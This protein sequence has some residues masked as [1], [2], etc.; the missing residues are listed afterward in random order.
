MP[1]PI[2]H[3]AAGVL[4]FRIFRRYLGSAGRARSACLVAVF[5]AFSLAPDLDSVA[6]VLFGDFGKYHNNMTHSM[7]FGLVVATVFALFAAPFQRGRTAVWFLAALLCC[8]LH[9]LMDYF[10][11]GRGVML[12]WPLTEIRYQPPVKL[13]YGVHWSDGWVSMRHLKTAVTEGAII[14]GVWMLLAA[15]EERR[16]HIQAAGNHENPRESASHGQHNGQR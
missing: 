5:A 6:G 13:F 8:E 4:L 1:S 10:T 9:V 2:A 11:I 12:A 7:A 16:D 14:L 3:A 15:K